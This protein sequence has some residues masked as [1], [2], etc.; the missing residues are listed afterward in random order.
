MFALVLG[1]CLFV[2]CCSVFR[3]VGSCLW[4]CWFVCVFW[5]P[6][7]MGTRDCGV[8]AYTKSGGLRLS[9]CVYERTPSCGDGVLD[10]LLDGTLANGLPQ[11]SMS[12]VLDGLHALG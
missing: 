9:C 3:V 10:G 6:L 4:V 12:G 8:R 7:S 1:L 5:S 11:F 2:A